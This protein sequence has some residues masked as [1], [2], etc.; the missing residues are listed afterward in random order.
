MQEMGNYSFAFQPNFPQDQ[1]HQFKATNPSHFSS[2]TATTMAAGAEATAAGIRNSEANMLNI[3][4]HLDHTAATHLSNLRGRSPHTAPPA[5]SQ[6]TQTLLRR[7]KSREFLRGTSQN[8]TSG[9]R[10]A[11]ATSGS[12]STR[13]S[14]TSEDEIQ[15][16]KPPPLT[17]GTVMR[18]ANRPINTV[19]LP[20]AKGE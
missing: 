15:E 1:L 13:T 18:M 17:N 7:T 20:E 14:N 4:L 2:T 12:V 19:F 9:A 3:R 5:G 11:T 6:R 16:T 10:A 8:V